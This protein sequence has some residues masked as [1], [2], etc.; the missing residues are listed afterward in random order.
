MLTAVSVGW[1]VGA[2]NYDRKGNFDPKLQYFPDLGH[3]SNKFFSGKEISCA[4]IENSICSTH[5]VYINENELVLESTIL[6]LYPRMQGSKY[7]ENY[8]IE[9]N[10]SLLTYEQG[11]ALEEAAYCM[12]EWDHNYQHFIIETLPKIHLAYL[13][14]TCPIILMD[15]EHIREIVLIAYPNRDFIFLK[16]NSAIKVRCLHLPMP[17][18]QNFE[19]CWRVFQNF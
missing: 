8:I 5:G 3:A 11:E 16:K 2:N 17:V 12:N 13:K 6:G 7:E 4:T 19:L 10:P 15:C 9:I 18:A 1:V 14:T